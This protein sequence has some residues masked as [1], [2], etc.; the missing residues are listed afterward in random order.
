MTIHS[1][2]F[3]A[4]NL[5]GQIQGRQIQSKPNNQDS[6]LEFKELGFVYPF[7]TCETQHMKILEQKLN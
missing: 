2:K 1:P 3:P 6:E 7:Q 4:V 5:Q